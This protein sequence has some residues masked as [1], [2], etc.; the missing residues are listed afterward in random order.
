M[1]NIGIAAGSVLNANFTAQICTTSLGRYSSCTFRAVRV[2]FAEATDRSP[3]GAGHHSETLEI[4]GGIPA[5]A[6]A[7]EAEVADFCN[8]V[9]NALCAVLA[10]ST[11]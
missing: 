5:R 6:K 9:R 7:R 2:M 1:Q 10:N 3:S 8:G 11:R 4:F